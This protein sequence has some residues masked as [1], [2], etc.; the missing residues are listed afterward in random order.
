MFMFVFGRNETSENTDSV[1]SSICRR[2]LLVNINIK[3]AN[4]WSESIQYLYR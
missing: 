3:T 4:K 1:A 2:F